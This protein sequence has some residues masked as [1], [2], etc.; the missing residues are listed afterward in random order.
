MSPL[1]PSSRLLLLDLL[2]GR[3]SVRLIQ[4]KHRVRYRVQCTGVCCLRLTLTELS[5]ENI[6]NVMFTAPPDITISTP[7]K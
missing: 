6:E 5:S 1:P 4:A 2:G 7:L 3:V